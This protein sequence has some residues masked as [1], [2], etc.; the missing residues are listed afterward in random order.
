MPSV[1]VHSQNYS[2]SRQSGTRTFSKNAWRLAWNAST[3]VVLAVK[4]FHGRFSVCFWLKAKVFY[5]CVISV[6]FYVCQHL[7]AIVLFLVLRARCITKVTMSSVRR[8]SAGTYSNGAVHKAECAVRVA[9]LC[10]P[11]Y[12]L[13][14]FTQ[15][16]NKS[17]SFFKNHKSMS[18]KF[19]SPDVK[20]QV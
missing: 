1:I 12:M 3:W 5:F 19:L 18:L 11:K 10:S 9:N 4:T 20:F 2:Y 13:W 17:Y 7:N 15:I 14:T 16:N 6:L 8:T